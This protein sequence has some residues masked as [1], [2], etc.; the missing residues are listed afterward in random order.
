MSPIA[1]FSPGQTTASMH[2]VSEPM[3]G[4]VP[5]QMSSVWLW[6]TVATAPITIARRRNEE[7]ETRKSLLERERF[8]SHPGKVFGFEPLLGT[9]YH[10]TLSHK[11]PIL[12]I[13][14]ANISEVIDFFVLIC[15]KFSAGFFINFSPIKNPR[16]SGEPRVFFFG[17]VR[18]ASTTTSLRWDVN[19]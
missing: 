11:K 17:E 5:T 14:I 9:T 3:G 15:D 10:K 18:D 1:S 7:K 13:K 12:S 16:L 8:K 4:A 19:R 6:R 2:T